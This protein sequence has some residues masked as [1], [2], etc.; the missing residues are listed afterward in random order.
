[1]RDGGDVKD[2]I[3][4]GQRV[5]A[6]VVAE[7]AFVAQRFLRVHVTFDDK[8]G[9]GGDFEVVGLAFDEFDGFF[10]E[11]TGQQKFV[12][13]VRQ[14]RGGGKGEHRVAADENA[15]RH[16]RAGFVIA[17][18]VAR[19]DLLELP[20]HAGGAVV[21]NLDAIHAHVAF[22]GVG[23]LGDDARQRDE[24]AAIERPAFLNG[25]IERVG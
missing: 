23:V 16:A 8:I 2:R 1:M 15:H 14:R 10:A 12:E 18:A 9:I 3:R 17:A 7:R 6:G 4:L 19:A 21:V 13:A 11:I 22:A 24:T 5:I 20:V 25:K